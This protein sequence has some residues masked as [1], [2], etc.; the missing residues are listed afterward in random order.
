VV[1]DEEAIRTIITAMLRSEV[2]DT[3]CAGNGFEALEEMER[4]R[5]D[6]LLLD[7]IMPGMSGWDLLAVMAS[8]PGIARVPVV[9]LTGLDMRHDLPPGRAVLH[10][11]VER[12]LLLGV[13]RAMLAAAP[14][15]RQRQWGH[16]SPPTHG[17]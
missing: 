5:P 10:K 4:R 2:Y 14:T 1:D 3:V 11:P 16:E 9:V 7:L 17:L 15:E 6:L 8:R 12:E 13:M